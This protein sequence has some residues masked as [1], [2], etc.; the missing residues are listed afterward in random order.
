MEKLRDA[1]KRLNVGLWGTFARR[2]SGEE[3][4]S[5]Q[6][7]SAAKDSDGSMSEKASAAANGSPHELSS[8]PPKAVISASK[9]TS[10]IE[11]AKIIATETGKLE[12]LLKENGHPIPSFEVDSPMNFPKLTDDIKK[13]REEVLRAT[14]DLE[15]LV[16]GPTE[17]IR[18]MAWNVSCLP[19]EK[20]YNDT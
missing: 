19:M 15:A 17:S 14:K 1:R 3:K 16:T 5:S 11:L 18:W 4:R 8:E 7:I 13:S 10:L 20:I 6:V 9:T 2:S 12:T